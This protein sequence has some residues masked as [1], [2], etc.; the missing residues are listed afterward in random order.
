MTF[1]SRA[2]DSGDPPRDHRRA[3]ASGVLVAGFGHGATLAAGSS[4]PVY[5]HKG[6]RDSRMAFRRA[7]VVDDSKTA[8]QSLARRLA[9]YDLEVAFAD[10]GE[11][12]LDFL[13]QELVDVIFMD[14]TMP[15]MDGLEAVSAIKSN[16]RTATIPVMMYTTREGE[17]Y[18][19]QARALGAVGVLPKQFHPNV[20]FEMLQQLGL[21]T[22][23]RNGEPPTRDPPP[24]RRVTD[25]VEEMD[26]VREPRALED[27]VQTLVQR[28]LEAQHLKLH[29]ALLSAQKRLAREAA[30]EALQQYAADRAG[31][32]SPAP[33]SRH[34]WIARGGATVL[35]LAVLA[36]L[37]FGWQMVRQRDAALLEVARLQAA[38]RNELDALSR[39][40]AGLDDAVRRQSEDARLRS[41]AAAR[42]LTWSLNQQMIVPFGALPFDDTAA[43]QL[44]T[45]LGHLSAMD[46]HGTLVVTAELAPFCVTDDVPSRLAPEALPIDDCPALTNPQGTPISIG[47]LQSVAFASALVDAPPPPG[48][49]LYLGMRTIAV[50]DI[51]HF[52]GGLATA[53]QWNARAAARNRLTFDLE[54]RGA[55]EELAT[56]ER[57]AAY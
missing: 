44:M 37:A 55:R 39:R 26:P 2:S 14:H 31:E 46:F 10:C 22:D 25:V 27:S 57:P 51:D 53:G 13:H 21:V 12:A 7:L 33:E 15:G 38:T 56:R 54:P 18:V 36:L 11:A 3:G 48:I 23:R 40:S 49:T 52:S 6:N 9:A 16:P 45:L 17:V 24:R 32:E 4:N 30:R 35:G 47:A 29:T 5:A 28:I 1:P 41:E 34:S 20:L 43:E 50:E 42:A 19:S 8:R